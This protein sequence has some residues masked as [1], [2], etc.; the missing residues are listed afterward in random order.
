MWVRHGSVDIAACYRLDSPGIEFRWRATLSSSVQ[1]GT[2]AQLTSN[3][4]ATRSP[5]YGVER[6]ERSVNHST[7]PAARLK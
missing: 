7:S 4:K 6:P 2:D 5:F 3:T 1:T